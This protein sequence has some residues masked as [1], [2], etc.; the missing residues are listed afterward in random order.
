VTLKSWLTDQY[1]MHPQIMD[2]IN[3]FYHDKLA[4]RIPE[5]D[6]T[7]GHGLSP[8]IPESTHIAWIPTDWAPA[9]YESRVG[10]SRQNVKEV[11]IIANLVGRIDEIW[12]QRPAGEPPKELGVIT[13]YAAQEHSLRSRL[14][15]PGGSQR[16]TNLDVR[17]GTV[18]RFQGM[19]KPIIIVSLVC[20]NDRRDIGF[21]RELERINVAFSR[22]QELLVIVGSRELFCRQASAARAAERYAKVA[23]VVVE[24]GG[25]LNAADFLGR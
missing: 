22:A 20:N 19:E 24:N 11:E 5:P 10:T 25:M 8:L 12:A 21:A 6:T 23:E 1:R 7:R 4:C 2:A 13:F 3:Q 18:D 16:F 15:A 17:L 14:L 9:F